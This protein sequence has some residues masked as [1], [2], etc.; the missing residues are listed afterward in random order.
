MMKKLKEAKAKA[1][2]IKQELDEMRLTTQSVGGDIE[3]VMDGNRRIHS[4]KINEVP[5]GT[6]AGLEKHMMNVM[7]RAI[8][9]ANEK[10]ESK[11]KEVA[12]DYLPNIPGMG[13]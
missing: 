4:I 13:F 1:E 2:V 7:N 12:K 6:L 9:E 8:Q 3:V 5:E 11:M 10:N